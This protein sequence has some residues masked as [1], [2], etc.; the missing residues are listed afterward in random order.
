[1]QDTIKLCQ[2]VMDM[3]FANG[4]LNTEKTLFDVSRLIEKTL[5]VEKCFI[6]RCT[7][8]TFTDNKDVTIEVKECKMLEDITE[9]MKSITQNEV[10]N[11][12]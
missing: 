5:K 12:P 10:K 6:M 9:N 11:N 2:Q 3:S 7:G 1:M 8:K 4:P